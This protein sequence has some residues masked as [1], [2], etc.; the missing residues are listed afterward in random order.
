M[1]AH[2]TIQDEETAGEKNQ[3]DTNIEQCFSQCIPR[4]HF[5][6]T[7]WKWP[8]LAAWVKLSAEEAHK[9]E[10]PTDAKLFFWATFWEPFPKST[11]LT[12]SFNPLN[13]PEVGRV[14]FNWCLGIRRSGEVTCPRSL[15]FYVKEL[16]FKHR[17]SDIKLQSY[18]LP[19]SASLNA[20]LQDTVCEGKLRKWLWKSMFRW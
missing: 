18:W 4:K 11:N 3:P 15:S 6:K 2:C 8:S 5:H 9:S 16:W 12:I 14:V 19:A 17:T 1:P 13:Y 7:P 10:F 20:R